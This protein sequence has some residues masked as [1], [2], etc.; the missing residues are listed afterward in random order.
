MNLFWAIILLLVIG[1]IGFC[2]VNKLGTFLE[3]N[4]QNINTT[5]RPD[6][7]HL[8]FDAPYLAED[9]I[10]KMK[11]K[12]HQHHS[13][14]VIVYSG[15]K[16]DIMCMLLAGQLDYIILLNAVTALDIKTLT[17]KEL[18]LKPRNLI[19]S[20]ADLNIEMDDHGAVK[21]EA[22]WIPRWISKDKAYFSDL[23]MK[24]E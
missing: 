19:T 21:A 2:C 6:V 9:F 12:D 13:M 20:D 10:N 15:T 4:F 23:I 5:E 8:G 1:V 14:E 24:T 17:Y 18:F 11:E 3:E 16:D 7:I 22:F